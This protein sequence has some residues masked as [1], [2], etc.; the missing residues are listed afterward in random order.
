MIF[1]DP[2]YQAGQICGPLL[3]DGRR[4]GSK[5]TVASYRETPLPITPSRPTYVSQ[6]DPTQKHLV[7]SADWA[8][9]EQRALD[10]QFFAPGKPGF[11]WVLDGEISYSAQFST[12]QVTIKKMNMKTGVVEDDFDPTFTWKADTGRCPSAS[13]TVDVKRAHNVR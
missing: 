13:L 10:L 8:L 9:P 12:P 11:P 3:P 4:A 1:N 2:V 7:R 6:T 5:V